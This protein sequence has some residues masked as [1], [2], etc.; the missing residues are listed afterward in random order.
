MERRRILRDK[1]TTAQEYFPFKLSPKTSAPCWFSLQLEQR[2]VGVQVIGDLH[3]NQR[4]PQQPVLPVGQTGNLLDQ[5]RWRFLDPFLLSGLSYQCLQHFRSPHTRLPV[6][7]PYFPCL[8]CDRGRYSVQY[9]TNRTVPG[10]K[11]QCEYTQHKRV[12]VCSG[13]E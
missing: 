2:M 10:P 9:C 7:L 13:R 11:S 8:W 4:H 5:R 1:T 6:T 3:R 12:C